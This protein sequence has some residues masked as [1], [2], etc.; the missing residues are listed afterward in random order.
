MDSSVAGK[1]RTLRALHERPLLVLP[2]IWDPGSAA[3]AVRA[4]AEAV[5]TTSGG[6]SWSLGRS[7]GEGL[8]SKDMIAAVRRIAAAVAVPVTADVEGGYGDV[9]AIV[10]AVVEAGAAGV[11]IEDSRSGM[12][13]PVGE[14]AE[15]LT[16]AREAAASAGLPELVINARTD[17]Y[18]L[19]TGDV[20]ERA[21]A[22]AAAGVDCLFVPGLLDLAALRDLVA[23]S[24]L[25]VNVMAGPGGPSI[26]ELAAA[27]VRRVSVGTAIAQAAYGLAERS[28]REL[29]TEGT[30]RS[31]E[32]APGY[33]EID[34]LFWPH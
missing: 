32:R 20:L 27:G 17:V 28:T 14:Q 4:G 3:V 34:S 6:V 29:L 33:S 7:D 25:P 30:Y 26:A 9:A 22:Y 15:R 31:L 8:T 19:G 23:V 5:A 24:P 12:L 1:A 2:N 21:T 13:V 10:R 18:L 16:A 11:N